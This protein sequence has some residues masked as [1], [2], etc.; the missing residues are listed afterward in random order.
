MRDTHAP[1]PGA[2]VPLV[3]RAADGRGREVW[4]ALNGIGAVA[5]QLWR[6]D[7]PVATD[8]ENDQR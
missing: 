5:D 2:R 1:A 8:K 3:L 4:F 6:I 7:T